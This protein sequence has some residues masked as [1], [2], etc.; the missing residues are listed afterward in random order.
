VHRL[1]QRIGL[2]VDD[3]DRILALVPR[4]LRDEEASAVEDRG[5]LAHAVRAAYRGLC[6]RSDVVDLYRAGEPLHEVPFTMQVDGGFVRGTIDCIVRLGSG[7][8]IVLEFKTGRP[9]PEH[10]RQA[11]L[12]AR[13]AEAMFPGVTTVET[14]VIHTGG[15]SA[16]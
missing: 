10:E 8:V 1:L 7:R 2:A 16:K 3:D 5:A 13:A 4:L 9:R 11:A 12:Y 15:M 6:A 14:R